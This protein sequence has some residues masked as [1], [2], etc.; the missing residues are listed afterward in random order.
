MK[1]YIYFLK[2]VGLVQDRYVYYLGQ[3]YV[4]CTHMNDECVHTGT[5][6]HARKRCISSLIE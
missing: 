5:A 4:Y 1:S 2:P 6:V 3:V